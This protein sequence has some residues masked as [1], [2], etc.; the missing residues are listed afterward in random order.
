M[1]SYDVAQICLNGHVINRYSQSEPESNQKHCDKC[2]APTITL[3]PKCQ[4]PIR[5]GSL[6]DFGSMFSYSAPGFC[7]NCG[8]PFPWTESRLIAAHELVKE[9][10]NI[11]EEDRTTLQNS[12][13]ELVKDTPSS[14]VAATKFKRII[15]KLLEFRLLLDNRRAACLHKPPSGKILENKLSGVIKANYQDKSLLL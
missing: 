8:N 13:D 3:C 7:R 10:E 1:N 14:T 5:G 9:L 11:S 15:S 4:S 12:I 6:D 2:G